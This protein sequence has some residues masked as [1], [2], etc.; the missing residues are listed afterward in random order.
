DHP[1][2]PL[3]IE[4]KKHYEKASHDELPSFRERAEVFDEVHVNE[5]A[6]D[7]SGKTG[8]PSDD[9]YDEH[10]ERHGHVEKMGRNHLFQQNE[11]GPRQAGDQ[12]GKSENHELCGVHVDA[13]EARP[14][15]V[16]LNPGQ[17]VSQGRLREVPGDEDSENGKKECEIVKKSDVAQV[18]STRQRDGDLSGRPTRQSIVSTG[19]VSPFPRDGPDH[20]AQGK[21][22]ES[23]VY[24]RESE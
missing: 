19:E 14:V 4:Q 18:E 21:G 1:R 7:R 6:Y 17:C 16:R 11:E 22:C 13:K 10:V 9:R 3:W 23:E 20:L 24:L 8:V 15:R 5:R 12:S 2:Y